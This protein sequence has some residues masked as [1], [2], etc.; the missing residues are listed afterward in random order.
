MSNPSKA[1]GT[2][3]EN[4]VAKYLRENGFSEAFRLAPAGDADAEDPTSCRLTP[5]ALSTVTSRYMCISIGMG[6][7]CWQLRVKKRFDKYNRMGYKG[8]INRKTKG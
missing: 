6:G 5:F 2:R 4:S 7:T 3:W 8:I 1:K